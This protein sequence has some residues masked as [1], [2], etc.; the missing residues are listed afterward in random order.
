ME[1]KNTRDLANDTKIREP[2]PKNF[3]EWYEPRDPRLLDELHAVLDGAADEKPLQAFY[4][5]HPYL[6]AIAFRPHCC[7]VFS[8]PRLGG[9]RH[10]PDF[11]YCD[12]DSLGYKWVLVE[13]ES[14]R[15]EA[16]T[17]NEAISAMCQHAV[18]QILDYRSWLRDNALAE[19]REFPGISD[20]CEG[21]IVIGRRD[22][23]RTEKER[24]RL[25]DFREQHIEVASY[26][27]LLYEARDHLVGI[28]QR[29]GQAAPHG[30]EAQ[31]R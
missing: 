19:Q 27:R 25:A 22:G 28:N 20:R 7:W 4:E 11:L 29:V 31:S 13:L 5:A 26:D 17:K 12:S 23:G 3:V 6:L 15:E 1:V 16:T 9:G 30:S 2:W 10:I 24:R 8:H 18:E 14:P 21:Y